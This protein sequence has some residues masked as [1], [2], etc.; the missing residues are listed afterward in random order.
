MTRPIEWADDYRAVTAEAVVEHLSKLAAVWG[1][2]SGPARLM[3]E[4]ARRLEHAAQAEA[5]CL[6][7]CGR[8]HDAFRPD[9][10][11][12]PDFIGVGEDMADGVVRLAEAY[13]DAM[14]EMPR[15]LAQRDL[16]HQKELAEA[17][18]QRD[19]LRNDIAK[20]RGETTGLRSSLAV[21][22]QALEDAANMHA[23]LRQ[24]YTSLQN[25]NALLEA[26]AD[27]LPTDLADVTT[28]EM[29]NYLASLGSVPMG[30]PAALVNEA[31]RRLKNQ[32]ETIKTLQAR[33]DAERAEYERT[34]REAVAKLTEERRQADKRW[35]DTVMQCDVSERQISDLRDEL[36]ATKILAAD[37]VELSNRRGEEI[38]DL[39]AKL[40]EANKTADAARAFRCEGC[41]K[42]V[43]VKQVWCGA[44]C[45]QVEAKDPATLPAELAYYDAAPAEP[46]HDAGQTRC[47]PPEPKA[48]WPT[49]LVAHAWSESTLAVIDRHR[50]DLHNAVRM[51]IAAVNHLQPRSGQ[52]GPARRAVEA[53][54][55]IMKQAAD[56]EQMP[57]AAPAGKE[58]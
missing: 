6:R 22:A 24:A 50:M 52:D 2:K 37:A 1:D 7:V 15:R 49:E 23:S 30:S 54:E 48:A 28:P 40:A 18:S 33:I 39:Q 29:C 36:A 8:L 5:E 19:E 14:N 26:V 3:T 25:M 4:A 47:I 10:G 53:A 46:P 43:D 20:L 17:I 12:L 45:H 27:G 41:G 31:A 56:R 44:C 11:V 13:R 42:L 16:F 21:Q 57:L 35:T 51:L 55:K 32:G 58:A 34:L 9:H 38:A